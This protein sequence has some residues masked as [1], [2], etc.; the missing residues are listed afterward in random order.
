MT[1][2]PKLMT[3]SAPFSLAGQRVLLTGA[4]GAIGGAIARLFAAQGASVA[5]SGRNEEALAACLQGLPGA[6]HQ[7]VPFALQEPPEA[8]GLWEKA[9]EALG[10]APTVLVN[11]AGL[12]RDMIAGRLKPEAWQEVLDVNLSCAFF[13]AQAALRVMTRE[14]AGRIIS[15]SS[16]VATLGNVGQANYIASKAGLEGMTRA[17]AREAGPRGVTINC[18]APGFVESPMTAKLPEAIRNRFLEQIP[19]QRAGQPEDIA[20]A[21][22]FLA[23]PSGAWV[24]GQTLHINGGMVMN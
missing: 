21:C 18:V 12:N 1:N 17:L 5:L 11:N 14:R 19:L 23:G 22:L 2:G 24:T 3:D 6:G 10:G 9:T 7:V 15:I 16:V 13:L 20:A 8:A 4:S